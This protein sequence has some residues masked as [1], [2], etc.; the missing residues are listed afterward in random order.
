MLNNKKASLS[1]LLDNASCELE[2][3]EHALVFMSELFE[4]NAT[5]YPREGSMMNLL[6]EKINS[7]RNELS[8]ITL[9][10]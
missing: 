8:D 5:K 1:D 10:L 6:A 7:V 4:N 3:V 2:K 9:K